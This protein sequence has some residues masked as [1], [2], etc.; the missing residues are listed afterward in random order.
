MNIGALADLRLPN[1]RPVGV[2]IAAVNP[3]YLETVIVNVKT[4]PGINVPESDQ[5]LEDR[6]K[7]A[8]SKL[9][10]VHTGEALRLNYGRGLVGRTARIALAE[11]V[12]QGFL[13]PDTK[14][15]VVKEQPRRR[16]Q[17]V[18]GASILM[19]SEDVDDSDGSNDSIMLSDD[20]EEDSLEFSTFLTAPSTTTAVSFPS[21]SSTPSLMRNG[22]TPN[23]IQTAP[24]SVGRVFKPQALTAPVP[25]GFLHPKP[26]EG[27]DEEARV[28]INVGDLAK[29]GCFSGDWI[30]ISVAPPPHD[31]NTMPSSPLRT[32]ARP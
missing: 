25:P 28:F 27:D 5:D 24:K 16:R 7:E 13:K 8:M 18:D 29:L 31:G 15:V 26:K 11:P 2:L 12:S 30:K 4:I 23:P 20:E 9:K 10:I 1:K 21:M 6:V 32:A 22:S 19:G 14:I 3:T 17:A